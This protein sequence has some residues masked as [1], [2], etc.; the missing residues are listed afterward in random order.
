MADV[1]QIFPEICRDTGHSTTSLSYRVRVSTVRGYRRAR[2][3]WLR[4]RVQIVSWPKAE[5]KGLNFDTL[6][7]VLAR[8]VLDMTYG[9]VS[10]GPDDEV[11]RAL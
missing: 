11:I 10:K 8:M 3:K 9:V 4:R 2:E 7:S 5:L 1:S 6:N